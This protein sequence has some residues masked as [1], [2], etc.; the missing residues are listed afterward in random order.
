MNSHDKNLVIVRS[1]V[2]QGLSP[3][4]AATRFGVSRQWVHTLLRRYEA[5]GDQGLAPGNRA[6]KSRPGT[7]VPV[8]RQRV[9][10]LRV[11]LSG[12]GADAGPETIAWHLQREGHHVPSTSTIRRILHAQGLI[13]PDP[14]KR[15]K[16]SY[17]RFEADLPNGCWQADITHWFLADGTRVEILDFLDDHS[18]YLL[19]ARAAPAFSGPMV[20]AALQSLIDEYGPPASTLTD[21]GLV[22]TA[23]LAGRKG[24]RNGFEK[25][26][27]AH[28]IRQKNGHPGH[29]QTQGKIERFHQTLKRW[30]R[31][32][33]RPGTISDLQTLLDTFSRWYNHER[34]HRSAG[35]RT[36]ATAYTALPKATPTTVT[37]AEWRTRTDKV[38][39]TGT[40]SL[41]YAGKLR[42]LGIG[43]A[44]AGQPVLMLINDQHVLTSH[45]ETGEILT[46]HHIDPTRDYQRPIRP[47]P[48]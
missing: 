29:P 39:A 45:A 30:L 48:S 35:R 15:P 38:A 20:T 11:Q 37:E 7:T 25:L 41:R 18:R 12:S 47:Q 34:P 13:V 9:I 6:P 36:P 40:V 46:E 27:Q 43:R 4:Q 23:R 10:E 26:L 33:P 2:Y 1:V 19:Y 3:T 8:V 5:R 17:I 42:H 32:R 16:S 22:F 24:G 44:H 21:N 14:K 28:Q 31:A